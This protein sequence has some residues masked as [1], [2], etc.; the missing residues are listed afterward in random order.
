MEW[1]SNIYRRHLMDMH[2]DD[3]DESFLSEFSP[4]TYVENLKKA[5]I[6]YAMLYLQSHAGLCYFPTKVGTMHKSFEKE[7]DKMKRLCDLCHENGIKVVGYYSLIY[8]T[9]EHDNHPE[10]RLITEN[11]KS[12]RA[13][14]LNTND[15]DMTFASPKVARYG[16][17]C[18]NNEGYRQFVRTQIDEMAEY[19]DLDG[20][21]FDM[22]YW[23]YSEY[24]HCDTCKKKYFDMFGEEIPKGIKYGTPEL[25]RLV[26]VKTDW[27]TEFIQGITAYI[28][29]KYP[30]ISVEHNYASSIAA[31]SDLGC[32]KGV[33]D[34]CDYVG[35]DLYGDLYYH[36]FACKYFYS[37]T[38]NQPFENMIS[39]CKPGLRVHT[40]TRSLDQM[41][42]NIALAMAHHGSTMMIDAID[43]VGTMDGRVYDTMGKAF[44]MQIPYE[45]YFTG[46]PIADV[47]IFYDR[48]DRTIYHKGN[49]YIDNR[50]SCIEAAKTLIANHVMCSC[51]GHN[52]IGG[53]KA[54]IAPQVHNV[55]TDEF[56]KFVED[57]GTL[58]FTGTKN[59]ELIKNLLGADVK[60]MLNEDIIYLAPKGN[61][62]F[63]YFNEKY[64]LP[65]EG[66]GSQIE[67]C[68][69]E[70][71]A[72]VTLPYTRPDEV[73]FASIHSNPP[74]IKTD[75]P[76]IVKNKVGKG[77][78]IW[79]A[80]DIEEVDTE[81]Y[82]QIFMNLISPY[83]DRTVTSDAPEKAEITLFEDEKNM[84]LHTVV[85]DESIKSEPI[86]S[87]NVSVKTEKKPEKVLLLPEEKNIEF[88]YAD[89]KVSFTVPETHIFSMM[90]IVK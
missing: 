33:R 6:N 72:T 10:W 66:C 54:V 59:A 84:L 26:K 74:G 89:G 1:Y 78:V 69:G 90:E 24:C 85:L 87:F 7:P 14:G 36:S 44:E 77:T 12:N 64:P 17:L 9:R 55:D 76:A 70:V 73:R 30:K 61:A 51:I 22:P 37:E 52:P 15:L 39:R 68:K 86:K 88:E 3:W 23:P 48:T 83:I 62:D 42:T 53:Y 18:P 63:L 29:E 57:G 35:G 50:Q 13:N 82:R 19:F 27:M 34:A 8:N 81:E 4:E 32:G 80:V 20:F 41:K 16:H 43:P 11:G 47:G 25:E 46:K 75:I 49:G 71:L 28:K 40:V 2:I 38:K 21:F 79:M 56:V 5:K 31:G 60:E 67:N 58:I 65:Y 45:K